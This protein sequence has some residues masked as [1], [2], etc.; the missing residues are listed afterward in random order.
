AEIIKG[1]ITILTSPD[2]LITDYFENANIGAALVNAAIMVLQAIIIIKKSK[3][4]ISGLLVASIF[5]L[6]GFS[7]FGKNLYNSTPI[8][9]GVYAY[10]KF[11]K[12]PFCQLTAIAL[13]GTAIGPVVSE[14]TFNFALPT[15]QGIF[16]G[17]LAGFISGFFMP[18]LAQHF[19][20]F[21]KGFSLY[22][23]G[24]TAGIIA[25]VC[26]A[27][28]RGL[29]YKVE[30]VYLVSKGNN[31]ELAMFLLVL[32]A[33]MLIAGLAA[34]QWSFKGYGALMKESGRAGSDF[35]KKYGRGVVYINMALLGIVFTA[36]ILI[37]GG[38]LNG[39]TIGGIFTVV[40]FGAIGKHLKNVLPILLGV[41]L[42]SYFSVHDVNST[43]A[44]LAALFGTT[45]APLSGYYG[46]V[47]GIIAGALHMIFASNLSFLNAGLNLYNNGFSG[48][49]I[50]AILVP[51]YEEIYKIKNKIKNA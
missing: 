37:V 42:A 29:G 49:F 6:A 38:K 19:I 48:G 34:N 1:N 21:H 7:L 17:V 5:T 32:F 36:Y 27:L 12:I 16:F 11:R 35:I 41:F 8:I 43:A 50:A 25:T 40:G 18:V 15:F 14:V 4:E 10:A 9:L 28:F 31:K 44:L 23:I 46:P 47:A 3:Q 26:T 20:N 2:N 51:I 33:M 45:L 22:N 39:P 30:T 13:F 24:F